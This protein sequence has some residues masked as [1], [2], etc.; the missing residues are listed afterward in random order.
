MEFKF[1]SNDLVKIPKIAICRLDLQ[2]LGYLNTVNIVIKPTAYAL[3]ELTFKVYEG[4]NFYDSVCKKMVLEVDGFGRFEIQKAEKMSDGSEEYKEVSAYSYEVSMNKVTLTY[5][6][7]T[8]FKLWDAISPQEIVTS[9][10][11]TIKDEYGKD[12]KVEVQVKRPT[13]LWI[14][15]EQTG[16]NIK[17]V[18]ESLM[19]SSRTMTID[20]AQAY[21]LL[22]GDISDAFKCYF[23]FD[24]MT[25]EISVYERGSV[26]D[27][28]D[29]E[30]RHV[31]NSGVNLSFRNLIKDIKISDISL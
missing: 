24:T 22:A 15:H 27:I 20:N 25:K 9:N 16:W 10:I 12:K 28:T 18:D 5:K 30:A 1:N 17:H 31:K 29:I 26:T 21:S 14:I 2:M 6:E 8:V 11:V 23:V 19:N 13:L 3:S 7:D 4:S